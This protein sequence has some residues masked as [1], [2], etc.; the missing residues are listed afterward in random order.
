MRTYYLRSSKEILSKQG[1]LS[2]KLKVKM[3]IEGKKLTIEGK[4]EDE[5]LSDRV[6]RAIDAGFRASSALQLLDD[7][8]LFE[9]ISIKSHTRRT[10][11][12]EVRARLIGK[13]GSTL[14]TLESL[15]ECEIIVRDEDNKVFV[16]GELTF[17]QD[18]VYAITSL[19]KGSKTASVYAYLEKA[20]R[21]QK[22][23]ALALKD[24]EK[25]K[26]PHT[27]SL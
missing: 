8:Y 1:L 13:E 22:Q 2:R 6:I 24:I 17:F 26:E 3:L 19:I 7:S 21:R 9:E 18:A 20:R 16:L 23:A 27:K 5:Y 12:R 4:P 11:L 10:T 14:Q 25:N 15:T